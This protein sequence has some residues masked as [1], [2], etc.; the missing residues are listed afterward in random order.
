M[1]VSKRSLTTIARRRFS[2]TWIYMYPNR[3]LYD[4]TDVFI[5]L[6]TYAL[7]QQQR[8]KIYLSI[9]MLIS[10]PHFPSSSL[11]KFFCLGII[12]RR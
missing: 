5:S 11:N 9:D 3:H 8:F 4:K 10:P 12:G 7:I 2:L 1:H 6:H